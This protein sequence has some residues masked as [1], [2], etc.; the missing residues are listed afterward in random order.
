MVHQKSTVPDNL[1]AVSRHADGISRRVPIWVVA[2]LILLLAAGAGA[3][4][5]FLLMPMD[6]TIPAGAATRYDGLEQGS[7]DE[8][9]PRLG[10]PDAP[11][12][13]EEFSSF[14]CSHC[15][16]FHEEQ[17]RDLLDKI[18]AGR[19]Q[20][21]YIPVSH[22]GWG[23]KNAAKGALCA[24]EQGQ[25]WAMH[26]TLFYWQGKFL[27]SPFSERRIEN[28]ARNLGLDSAAFKQCMDDNHPQAI[29]QRARDEFDRRHLSGTPTLFINGVQVR[30]YS[31]LENLDGAAP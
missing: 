27:A 5:Y 10:R 14:A 17:F 19:V 8:G 2:G 22:I 30:D 4:Y 3:V 23:A 15:R 21:V 20:F 31:E 6:G 16:T 1:P 26:D 13:V 28:G 12:I 24:G 25:F 11:F 29:L 9:F 7:T 18:A